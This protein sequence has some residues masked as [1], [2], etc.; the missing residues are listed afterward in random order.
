[1]PIRTET[2]SEQLLSRKRRKTSDF[3]IVKL[4]D[5]PETIPATP[6]ATSH[7]APIPATWQHPDE[8]PYIKSGWQDIEIIRFLTAN[9]LT[10]PA[11]THSSGQWV[12]VLCADGVTVVLP[13]SYR[14]PLLWV[15]KYQWRSLELVLTAREAIRQREWDDAKYE[16]LHIARLCAELV[17][18][19][20][21]SAGKGIDRAWRCGL[22]DRALLRYW[23]EWLLMRDEFVRHFW[24]EFGE[25]DFEADVLKR[26]WAQWVLKDHKGFSLTREEVARG[27][28]REQFTEGFFVDEAAGTFE[29]IEALPDP[30]DSPL[31]SADELEE[32]PPTQA[33]TTAFVVD[34]SFPAYDPPTVKTEI[35]DLDSLPCPFPQQHPPAK[36]DVVIRPCQQ[37]DIILVDDVEMRTDVPSLEPREAP[38]LTPPASQ[39]DHANLSTDSSIPCVVPPPVSD[40]GTTDFGGCPLSPLTDQPQDVRVVREEEI[41]NTGTDMQGIAATGDD[42]NVEGS[43]ASACGGADRAWRC[44][45]SARL[46]WR[47]TRLIS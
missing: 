43:S 7:L 34:Q 8:L 21:V 9:V 23:H 26:T 45:S 19:A 27:I 11:Q 17:N 20:R 5:G 18:A 16:I 30:P 13:R 37:G 15:A 35:A 29:W 2:A 10:I 24:Y 31:T 12:H 39:S 36:E 28:S 3:T 46:L 33:F 44:R 25:S 14:L 32:E 41:T 4:E 42:A 40:W 22:F 1:M 47:D 6:A 38:S